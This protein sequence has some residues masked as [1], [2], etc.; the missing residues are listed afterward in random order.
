[1]HYR[2]WPAHRA[3]P[4][5]PAFSVGSKAIFFASAHDGMAIA[6]VWHSA[7]EEGGALN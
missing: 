6:C 3:G 7:R 5:G 4:R 1:M 2:K